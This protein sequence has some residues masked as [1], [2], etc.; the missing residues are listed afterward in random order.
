MPERFA[1]STISSYVDPLRQW[2]DQLKELLGNLLGDMVMAPNWVINLMRL[3]SMG[4]KNTL[5][6]ILWDRTRLIDTFYGKGRRIGVKICLATYQPY[7]QWDDGRRLEVISTPFFLASTRGSVKGD[8][9]SVA[10]QIQP[11]W[12]PWR[13]DY[14][15]PS[16]VW[17]LRLCKIRTWSRI[18]SVFQVKGKKAN[19]LTPLQVLFTDQSTPM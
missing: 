19:Q 9:L 18:L 5:Q 6:A 1:L 10:I 14:T 12:R 15:A 4:A 2:T 17:S 16:M 3:I 7:S 11:F 13:I 8:A